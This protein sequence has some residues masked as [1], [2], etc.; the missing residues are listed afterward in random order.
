MEEGATTS[1]T[2]SAKT[3]KELPGRPATVSDALPMLPGVVRR[4]DGGLQI[5]SA[6]EHRSAMIVNRRCH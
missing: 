2:L 5:S 4:P 6:G 1:N 3:A